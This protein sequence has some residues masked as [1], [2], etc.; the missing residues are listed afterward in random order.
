[1]QW[2]QPFPFTVAEWRFFLYFNYKYSGGLM[3]MNVLVNI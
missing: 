3:F 1:M 2:S